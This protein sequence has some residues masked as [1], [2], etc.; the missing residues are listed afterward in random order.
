MIIEDKLNQTATLI[1]DR[2]QRNAR[3][4]PDEVSFTPP[5]GADVIGKPRA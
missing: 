2:V 1:F 5:P 3:V 4:S